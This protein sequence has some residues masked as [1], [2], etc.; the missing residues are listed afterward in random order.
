VYESMFSRRRPPAS[1]AESA[2]TGTS[3]DVMPLGDAASSPLEQ[4]EA[5][6]R[7]ADEASAELDNLRHANQHLQELVRRPTN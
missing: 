5:L 6:R 1:E 2:S 4:Q 3:L 7:R